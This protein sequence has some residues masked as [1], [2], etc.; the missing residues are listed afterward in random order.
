MVN[1]SRDVTILTRS[2]SRDIRQ[3]LQNYQYGI[4]FGVRDLTSI[5]EI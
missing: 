4:P 3:R 1:R 2:A 5:L